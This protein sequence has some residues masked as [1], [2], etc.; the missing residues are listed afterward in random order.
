MKQL[1]NKLE[2][3]LK[4]EDI[5]QRDDPSLLFDTILSEFQESDPFLCEHFEFGNSSFQELCM[6]CFFV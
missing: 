5:L 2:S 6:V 4:L 1:F 3:C